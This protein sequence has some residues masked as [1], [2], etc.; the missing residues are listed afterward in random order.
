MSVETDVLW[1]VPCTELAETELA[2]TPLEVCWF[3]AAVRP[4]QG[5]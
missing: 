5:F 2:N 4:D 1:I 3:E